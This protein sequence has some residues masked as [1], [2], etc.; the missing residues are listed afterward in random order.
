M[1]VEDFTGTA[2]PFPTSLFTSSACFS[3]MLS[4]GLLSGRP[5][6]TLGRSWLPIAYK[7]SRDRFAR[8]LHLVNNEELPAR[9]QPNFH[10]LQK[11]QPFLTEMKIRFSEAYHPHCEVSVHDKVQGSVNNET[12]PTPQAQEG[13]QDL[14]VGRRL[15]RVLLGHQ[16]IC[17]CYIRPGLRLFWTS[18]HHSLASTTKCTWTITF[19]RFPS[20]LLDNKT[21][22]CGT[23]QGKR[24][25]F[26]TDISTDVKS[27]TRGEYSFRQCNNLVALMWKDKKPVTF[28]STRW[29]CN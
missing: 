14:G 3:L 24:K 27:L 22:A 6:G 7:I 1:T 23:I 21:Y 17:R 15:E 8:Y 16:P 13:F 26:P 12:V 4:L 25:C 18:P 9:G 5:T 2:G 10:H 29:V 19:P 28:L 11:V 20:T